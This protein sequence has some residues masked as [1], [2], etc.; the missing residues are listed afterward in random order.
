MAS[1]NYNV[2]IIGSGPGGYVA[3]I[4]AAQLGAK[5]A[6]V[7]KQ[8]LGGT[9]L[10][11]GCI[12][13][14]AMLHIANVLHNMSSVSELGIHLP[15]QPTFDMKQAVAF[16]DKVVKRVTPAGAVSIVTRSK[17]TWDLSGGGFAP[18]G[19]LWVLEFR[20]YE[21]RVRRIPR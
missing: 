21:A 5:V 13:S 2:A 11:V 9:C 7:E 15:Q 6:I 18:N 1:T 10:N 3:A 14:K 4:R 16:K 12:P 8:Y 20:L 19:E 17:L